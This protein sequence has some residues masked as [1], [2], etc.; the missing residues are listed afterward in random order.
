MTED[1]AERSELRPPPVA[2]RR[3]AQLG[4]VSSL[5]RL[6]LLTL[7][8]EGFALDE[9]KQVSQRPPEDIEE[10]VEK[11]READLLR[12]HRTGQ[13]DVD[14]AFVPDLTQ[15]HELGEVLRGL[16]IA[17]GHTPVES[18]LPLTWEPAPTQAPS[19]TVVQGTRVGRSFALETD[20]VSSRRG[21]IIGRGDHVDVP[22]DEDP[23]VEP[24][25]GEIDRWKG[26][27]EL[28]D[29]RTADRRVSLNG[30]TLDRGGRRKLTD[31]DLVGVGRSLLWYQA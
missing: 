5:R 25:A 19:L 14:R 21:W 22:L 20:S 1:P 2:R 17:Y 27:F 29:L 26:R 18:D 6:R 28:V 3:I 16:S 11:L 31:G 12:D 10:D 30:Q 4:T 13:S 24:E 9:V 15:L 8:A 23:Y 7:F